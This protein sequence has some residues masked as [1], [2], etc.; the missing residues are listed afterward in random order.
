MAQI[1]LLDTEKKH[2]SLPWERLLSAIVKLL[3]VVLILVLVY[4]GYA[5]FRSKV[6]AENIYN[7]QNKIVE[8]QNK[9]LRHPDRQE[10]LTRQGQIK[11]IETL[12]K[13]HSYWSKLLPELARV[14]L[15]NATYLAFSGNQDGSAHLVVSVPSYTDF[16]QFLQ[17][18]DMPEFNEN[19][20]DV[21]ITSVSK[22]LVGDVSGTK[23]EVNIKYD[24]DY[25]KK[26]PEKLPETQLPTDSQTTNETI[27]SNP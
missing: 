1:N 4:Y 14:T 6:L 7:L 3:V 9:I 12:F 19:F 23:F 15:K 11:E 20:S 26:A 8:M 2:N 5:Y 22:Y 16:D 10:L 27:T 17:V 24:S 21:K 25:I 18:F 13:N